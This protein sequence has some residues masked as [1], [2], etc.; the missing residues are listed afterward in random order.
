MS[1]ADLFLPKFCLGCGFLGCYICP[2]CEKKLIYIQ[3]DS[4]LYCGQPSPFGLT[5]V[6]CFKKD[7]LDGL[8]SVFYYNDFLKKIIKS[9][10]YK[11]AL[12]VWNEFKIIIKPERLNKISFYKKLATEFFFQPIPL[13][14][15]REKKRGFNQAEVITDFLREFLDF[16]KAQFLLRKK[17]GFPQAQIKERKKRAFNIRGAFEVINKKTLINKKII[18]VDDV[19]TTGA[20]LKEAARVLKKTGANKV[21][22]FTLARRH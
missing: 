14:L 8:I 4:C 22:A 1:L 7:C 19:A 16:P 17:E 13:S 21:F 15:L 10:K 2:K 20:T 18:L 6:L 11:R 12:V 3:K 9:F 5:H